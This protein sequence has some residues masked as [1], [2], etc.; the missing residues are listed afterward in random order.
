MTHVTIPDDLRVQGDLI[1]GGSI[2]TVSRSGITQESLAEYPVKLTDFRVH[3]ALQTN[4]PG[5]SAADDLGLTGGA[6]GSASPSLNSSDLK[7][8][9]ATT[10]YARVQL[11]LPPEYDAGQTVQ[12]RLHAG[13]VTTVADTAATID[14]ECYESDGEA[15][16]G[17]DLCTTAAQTINSLTLADKDFTITESGLSPGDVLDLRITMA[18][19]DAATGTA[20]QGQVG[21][22]S[23]LCDIRG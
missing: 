13:M 6:F 9:G 23:L 17:S 16:V 7:A 4:L 8:A 2:P 19:N 11:E 10:L 15:G 18:I 1:V 21:K 22:V 5:T 20:V 14:V 12:I 3:D